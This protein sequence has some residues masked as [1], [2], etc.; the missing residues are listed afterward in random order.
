MDVIPHSIQ[1]KYGDEIKVY[2]PDVQIELDNQG[3]WQPLLLRARAAKA[4]IHCL[5]R[6]RGERRLSPQRVGD[7]DRCHLRRYPGT[8]EH[9]ALDCRHYGA[10]AE[11]NGRGSYEKG[12]IKDEKDGRVSVRLGNGLTPREPRTDISATGVQKSNHAMQ[13]RRPQQPQMSLLGLL[14][15]LWERA[16]LNHWYPTWKHRSVDALN[17]WLRSAAAEITV[18]RMTLGDVLLLGTRQDH[19]E[20]ANRQVCNRARRERRRIIVIAP[21]AGFTEERAAC[22]DGVIPLKFF[23]GIP[24][25]Q[26]KPEYW[27]H[28]I[29]RFPAA[30]A[31]WKAGGNLDVV[32]IALVD[33]PQWLPSQ[34][35]VVSHVL[36]LALM[37]VSVQ[38]IPVDSRH[39]AHV[40]EE[41]VHQ[42]RAFRKPLR[43]DAHAD[44]VLPDFELIDTGNTAAPMEVFG[45]TDEAYMARKAEKVDYYNRIYGVNEWWCWD[46]ASSPSPTTMPTFPAK[47][48]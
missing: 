45:R 48:G 39:E 10:R 32:A 38:W 42:H 20:E 1:I 15:L 40:V 3:K 6:G 16:R 7:S 18:S 43:Y 41:L 4:E 11:S 14:H 23:S 29:Q 33:T 37:P 19:G 17:Y 30:M 47:G 35:R 44:T 21:L 9:H 5:C 34:K 22:E 46:A 31:A 12:V 26:V 8:G 28:I 13:P 27:R 25:L 24:P 2:R 36:D